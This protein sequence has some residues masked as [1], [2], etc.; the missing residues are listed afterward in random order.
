MEFRVPR[1]LVP[2]GPQQIKVHEEIKGERANSWEEMKRGCG[3]DLVLFSRRP[4]SGDLAPATSGST[5]DEVSMDL[6]IPCQ[7]ISS[8]AHIN[9]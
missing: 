8:V 4:V 6:A 7:K 3:V 5:P 9:E 1:C 2:L